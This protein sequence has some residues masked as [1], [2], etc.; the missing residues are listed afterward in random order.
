MD[1]TVH[2]ILLISGLPASGKSYFSEWLERTKSFVHFDV[3]KDGRVERRELQP[4]W[5]RCFEGKTAKPLVDAL[6]KIGSP[7]VW[8]WGFP[9]EA[10]S[11]VEMLKHEG[12]QIWWF[13]ADHAAARR[14]FIK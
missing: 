7:V 5:D 8:N 13:D 2:D 10:L 1:T 12:V 11:V 6:R 4:L 9:P 14:A 3:E